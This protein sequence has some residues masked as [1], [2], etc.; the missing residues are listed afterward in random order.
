MCLKFKLLGK[1][2]YT[3]NHRNTPSVLHCNLQDKT[4][5]YRFD[6]HT[7]LLAH[8]VNAPMQIHISLCQIINIDP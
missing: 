8:V 7:T 5:D 4:F 1:G 3:R 2:K 6:S